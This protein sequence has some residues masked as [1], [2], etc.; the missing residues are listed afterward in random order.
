MLRSNM[1]GTKL[2]AWLARSS[3]LFKTVKNL[4]MK[5]IAVT[6]RHVRNYMIL[7]EQCQNHGI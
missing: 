4:A 1:L 5:Y 7:I 2:E 6:S 3:E